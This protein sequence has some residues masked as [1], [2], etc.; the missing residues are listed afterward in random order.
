MKRLLSD[1]D[2]YYNDDDEEEYIQ[3]KRYSTKEVIPRHGSHWR[4]RWDSERLIRLAQQEVD[5][6]NDDV[7]VK[8]TQTWGFADLRKT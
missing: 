2:K 6:E 7:Q 1:I 4:P 3:L 5:D 8:R